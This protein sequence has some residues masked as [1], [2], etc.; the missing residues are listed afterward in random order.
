VAAGIRTFVGLGL[1]EAQ[2]EALTAYL[3]DCAGRAPAHR[4]VTPDALHL[5]LRF[6]GHLQPDLLDAVRRELGG[7]HA[8]PFRLALAGR[9]EFGHRAAPQVVWLGVGEGLD[10][11]AALAAAVEHACAAAGVEPDPRGFRA[12]VT[13]GRARTESERL[14]ALADPPVLA[15]W[16]VEE[17]VLYESRLAQRPRYMALNRYP[18]TVPA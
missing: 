10:R 11:C 3:T 12:H 9:G 5:T 1:P 15:P 8:P 7:L 17:F 2:R 16:M 13:L 4:W 6:L 18:L 14:P